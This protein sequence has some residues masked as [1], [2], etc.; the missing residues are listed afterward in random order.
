M[1]ILEVKT[2]SSPLN[3]LLVSR[4]SRSPVCCI[5][6]ESS[7]PSYF[8]ANTLYFAE[9]RDVGV[10]LVCQQCRGYIHLGQTPQQSNHFSWPDSYMLAQDTL[11]SSNIKKILI[12][13]F[14]GVVTDFGLFCEHTS[15]HCFRVQLPIL[16]P[17]S[18]LFA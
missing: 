8:S 17:C 11:I 7:K 14:I 15:Q 6:R 5:Y 10:L 3:S 13:H 12:Q 4:V 9:S 16:D 1:Q 18:S 2:S